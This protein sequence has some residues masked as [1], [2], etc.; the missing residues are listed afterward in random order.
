M[1]AEKGES[2]M[3]AAT[4]RSI[5][6]AAALLFA[7][8]STAAQVIP[9]FV[10]VPYATLHSRNGL[11]IYLPDI[12][13]GP[14]PVVVWIHGGAWQE[15]NKGSAAPYAAQLLPQGI[16]VVGI[17]YRLAQD[18]I[19]PAQIHDC[20]AAIRWLRANAATY[21]LD[22]SRIGAWGSSAGG[23][24]VAL[25]GTSG[26]V[27]E[28][29]GTVGGNLSFSSRVQAA[30]DYFGP[31]DLL[32]INLDVTTPPGSTLNHDAPNSPESRLIGFDQAGEGIAVLR[33]NQTNP[34]P[35]YP[36]K[37][38][39]ITLANPITH[40]TADDPV[41]YIAHGMDDTVVPRAQSTKLAN[42]LAAIG[43]PR[44]FDL[45]TGTGH[46]MPASEDALIVDFFVRQFLSGPQNVPTMGE[47]GVAVM[48][49]LLTTAGS[50]MLRGRAILTSSGHL[51]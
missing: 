17:N 20:K 51:P 1:G 32:N 33:A 50:V 47:W 42:A 24:L 46:A 44:T 15:G 25:V 6:G 2:T 3:K 41:F 34:N 43:V 40:V 4:I 16:A 31:T 29:E 7:V 37:I 19:F 11:D 14:F 8:D 12:G 10:D 26:N 18:A 9:D 38:A 23:H 36:A 45:V 21:N 13:A 28:A 39:L 22:P 30:A 35:P 48:V 49:L 27:P 5:L